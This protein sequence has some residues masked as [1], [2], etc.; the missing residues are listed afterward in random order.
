MKSAV[1]IAVVIPLY[2]KRRVVARTI[3]SVLRQTRSPEEL[4]IVDDGSTDGSLEKALETLESALCNNICCKIIKQENAG[5]SVAR[6]TGVNASTANYIAF[7]DADD[8]WM[9]NHLTEIQQ[10]ATAVPSAGILSTRHARLKARGDPVA[11]P[12]ALP[13]GF[14]GKV[15]N[16]LSTYRKGYGVLHT[17]SIAVSR[18]AW[19]RSG[20]FPPCER[21]S[22]DIHLWLR[23][24][25][26]E[27]FAHSDQLTAIWHEEETGVLLRGGVMPAHFS[28]FL[29][30]EAGRAT[31]SNSD[32]QAFLSTNLARHVG[33]HRLRRDDRVVAEMVRLSRCLPLHARLKIYAISVMPRKALAAIAVWRGARLRR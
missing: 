20:G 4:V 28:Y 1:S 22:Q 12:S 8:E 29:G 13:R 16:A 23:L 24:L 5:V 25:L 26:S 19:E 18:E 27:I 30:S 7:L 33:G 15:E 14:F 10:L 2:N 11:E 31:L 32:L 3:A 17:S 21:K 6:N 9:P